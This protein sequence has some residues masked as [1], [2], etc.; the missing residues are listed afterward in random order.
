MNS[1]VK[2]I[3]EKGLHATNWR[4]VPVLMCCSRKYPYPSHGRFFKLNPPPLQKFHVSA[5]LS[6]KNWAFETPLPL[7]ISINL[8]WGG[9]GYFLELHNECLVTVLTFLIHS[10]CKFY[11][12]LCMAYKITIFAIGLPYK[13]CNF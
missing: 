11:T 1:K 10:V 12:K 2:I 7:G 8:P 5:K 6:L 3:L 9:H 13:H 4:D